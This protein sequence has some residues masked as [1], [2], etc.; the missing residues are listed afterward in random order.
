MIPLKIQL[1]KPE[2]RVDCLALANVLTIVGL[3]VLLGNSFCF[4]TGATINLPTSPDA[5]G[6]PTAA[7]M[8]IV[9]QDKIFYQGHCY[10][11]KTFEYM[12]RKHEPTRESTPT[13]LLKTDTSVSVQTVLDVCAIAKKLGFK[14]V[15][16]A[17]KLGKE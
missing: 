16:L 10:H 3:L 4:N 17:A 7:L 13:L 11:L 5:I 6:R 1:P 15:H 9:Q 2:G 14:E 12:L 8:T